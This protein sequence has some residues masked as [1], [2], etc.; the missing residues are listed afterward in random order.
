[1]NEAMQAAWSLY[2]TWRHLPSGEC[3]EQ[4]EAHMESDGYSD[5]E[6]AYAMDEVDHA[7][8]REQDAR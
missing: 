8:W 7:T 4:I 6:I 2:E 1:M 3:F 5:K